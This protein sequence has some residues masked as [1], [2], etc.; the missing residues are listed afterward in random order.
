MRRYRS[1]AESRECEGMVGRGAERSG[2]D[3]VREGKGRYSRVWY[4]G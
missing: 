1:G 4:K 3:R 2:W